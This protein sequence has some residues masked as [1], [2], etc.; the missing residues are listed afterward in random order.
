M[1]KDIIEF[2]RQ[3]Y[4]QPEG[5]IPL[6]APVFNGN[7]KKYLNQCIDTTYVSYV[8]EFVTQFEESTAAFTGSRHAVAMVNGTAA[9]HIALVV[10]GVEPGDEVITQ[11]LTFVATANAIRHAGAVPLFVDV[12]RDTLGMSPEKLEDFLKKNT[13]SNNGRCINRQTGKTIK[14]VLPV[15]IFGHPCRIAEI[16]RIAAQYG[17]RVVEDA[18]ES[19]GSYYNGKHT[20]TFGDIGILSYNGNKTITTGGGGMLITDDEDLAKKA[21][22]IT[23][24][25]KVPHPWEYEHDQVGYNYRLTNLNAAVGVAQ[26]E[27]IGDYLGDKRY[28]AEQY[29]SFFERTGVDFI[30]EPGNSRSNFWLNAILLKNRDERDAFLKLTNEQ[31]VMT[32]PIWTLMN[33]SDMFRDCVTGNLDNAEWLEGRVV[34]L[35]S[36]VRSI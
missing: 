21:R 17:L 6:H 23:T 14:A 24:T 10:A 12:D 27:K 18:A 30:W 22:H 34:N 11:P 25:A 36:S 5:F 3:L 26:M 32:R 1:Y 28:I 8:G 7:E 33:K 31:K 15:H 9:L 35:P 16:T 19:L 20:G 29:R 4:N 2:I 13:T